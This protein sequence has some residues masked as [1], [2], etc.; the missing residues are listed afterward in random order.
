M[1][2]ICL[3]VGSFAGVFGTVAS[4]FFVSVEGKKAN[5]KSR[6]QPRPEGTTDAGD[7]E[8]IAAMA[9]SFGANQFLA[10]ELQK[11]KE[12][13]A[14]R[15]FV[16]GKIARARP[17]N[18]ALTGVDR[19]RAIGCL[20]IAGLYEA[21]SAADDQRPVMQVILNRARHPAWPN[22]VC[23]VVFQGMERRTGCQ[24]SFTCDGSMQRWRP[25]TADLLRARLL[26]DTMLS[27]E[28]DARVGWATHYHTDWVVPYWS[29][30]LD[31]ATAVES[32]LFFSWKGPWGTSAAFNS[33]PSLAEPRIS[34]MS[35]LE[36]SHAEGEPSPKDNREMPLP[37]GAED[38]ASQI[39]NKHPATFYEPKFVQP[40]RQTMEHGMSPGRWALDAVSLCAK[41]RDCRVVGWAPDTPRPT[42]LDQ[43]S[44]VVSPPDLV[45]V[46]TLRDRRQQVY[47]NCSK[48]PRAGTSFC[49]TDPAAIAAL[50]LRPH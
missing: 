6:D 40:F 14:S 29:E 4:S 46:Q 44:I 47:W 28:I 45:Y 3:A 21:G 1:L 43:E 17:F 16:S 9:D 12:I 8:D 50:A 31:K 19:D 36:P 49:L 41:R 25:S 18:S 2:V 11:A 37:A 48:W 38:L 33:T 34:M 20:A 13:N 42:V 30:S 24:F 39:A 10:V 23:A 26:A 35:H 27:Q 7:M 15:P 32:H 22:S 5:T